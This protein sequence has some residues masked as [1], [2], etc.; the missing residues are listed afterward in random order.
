MVSISPSFQ[1]GIE[2]DMVVCGPAFL[3]MMSGGTLELAATCGVSVQ[4]LHCH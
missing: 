4:S 1:V 2:V 3:E